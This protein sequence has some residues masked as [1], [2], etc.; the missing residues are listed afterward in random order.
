MDI[1]QFFGYLSGIVIALSFVPY[2][3][4]IFRGNAKP[5]RASWFI[6]TILGVIS[7]FS[8]LAKGADA[9]LWLVGVQAI[10]DG[11]IFVLAIWYGMGG[12]ARRD[13]WALAFAGVS[14]ILW[15]LTNEPAV[16]LFL[17]IVIDASGA[18]LTMI[19]SYEQPATE[20]LLAWILT[21][22]GGFFAIFA[23]G[24]WNWVLLAFPVYVFVINVAIVSSILLGQKRVKIS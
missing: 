3:I 2:L 10:G 12:F 20:P 15:Y 4:S 1:T 17:A 9:S 13:K 7:F 11:L 23:V 14:L 18:I 19:K 5:E 6:W 21:F 8:Q 24:S 22:L 16:A